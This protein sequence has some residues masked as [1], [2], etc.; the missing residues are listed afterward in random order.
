LNRRVLPLISGYLFALVTNLLALVLTHFLSPLL[1]PT[2][3]PIFVAAIALS[4]WFYGVGV[5]LF[6]TLLATLITN[7]FFLPPLYILTLGKADVSRLGLFLLV[8]GIAV[9]LMR[10]QR[11]AA[12]AQARLGAIVAFSNDAIIGLTLD[13]S[14]TSWNAGAVRMYGYAANEVLK[15]L[16]FTIVPLEFQ[17]E[18]KDILARIRSGDATHQYEAVQ[19]QKSG[20]RIDTSITI[21][22]IRNKGAQI[23]GASMIARDITD[24]K[25]AAKKLQE[26][27]E[28]LHFLSMRLVE[29]QENER[30]FIARELHDEIGQIL[31]GLKLNMEVAAR[32][33][34]DAMREKLVQ[35][36][37]LVTELIEQ[38]SHLTLDLRP[39]MLDDLGLLPTLLWHFDRYTEVTNIQVLFKHAGIEKKRFPTEIETATYRIIQEAL[40]NVAR[41]ASANQVK[42][43]VVVEMERFN[44]QIMDNGEG[45]DSQSTLL[46]GKASGLVGI[47]ERADLLS[48][49]LTIQSD[50]GQGTHLEVEF[51]YQEL[52]VQAAEEQR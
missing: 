23:V 48:G 25:Q 22:P 6:S 12:E 42:V 15:Q 39:P 49:N 9:S 41:H 4:A 26:Y 18:M 24:R 14:I 21:S 20:Q 5:G 11:L 13:G 46:S 45:F 19:I 29:V 40:T 35:A 30:R 28:Q 50:P 3:F 38:I 33:P 43:W 8:T 16:I 36:Q 27:T 51:P 44:I 7:F 2:P 1:V 37:G 31:T 47:R 10:A 17:T 32:L 52:A 34:L